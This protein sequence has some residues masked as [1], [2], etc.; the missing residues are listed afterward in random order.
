MDQEFLDSPLGR[1]MQ[2]LAVLELAAQ[3]MQ[4]RISQCETYITYLLAK[5]PVVGPR[6]AAMAKATKDGGIN[7]GEAGITVQKETISVVRGQ[8]GQQIEKV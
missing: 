3:S 1:I 8:D 5:D 6:I 7:L 4:A 2:A